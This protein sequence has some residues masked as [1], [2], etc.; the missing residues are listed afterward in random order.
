LNV[1][2]CYCPP[3]FDHAVSIA[4]GLEIARGSAHICEELML[5]GSLRRAAA[6]GDGDGSF[7]ISAGDVGDGRK[8]GAGCGV[9]RRSS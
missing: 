8:R 4:H 2:D 3:S 6:E 7:D 1:A 9:L 5:E